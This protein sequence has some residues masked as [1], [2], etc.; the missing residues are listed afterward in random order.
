MACAMAVQELSKNWY[1]KQ[2]D[3]GNWMPV[4]HVPTNVHLDLMDNKRFVECQKLSTSILTSY[5]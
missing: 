1:F 5:R 2:T 3:T 4:A